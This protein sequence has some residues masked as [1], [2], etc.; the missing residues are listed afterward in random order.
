MAGGSGALASQYVEFTSKGL[1]TVQ[2]AMDVIKHGL[3]GVTGSTASVNSELAA[4]DKAA[5][6][7][8]QVKTLGTLGAYLDAAKGKIAG[9]ASGLAS[10]AG[11]G[12]AGAGAAVGQ[13]NQQLAATPVA[14]G[15]AVAGFQM[16][17]NSARSWVSAGLAG[18]GHGNLMQAQFQ[19]L[20]Q[21]IA[22]VFV[23]TINMVTHAVTDLAAW[24][25]RLTGDQQGVIRRF[26]EA[27]A[28]MVVVHLALTKV[29]GMVISFVGTMIAGM[30]AA[31]GSILTTLVP[32]FLTLVSEVVA[33]SV[34]MASAI[35]FASAGIST[36]LGVVGAV[37]SA[38]LSLGIAGTTVGVGLAVG[39]QSGRSALGELLA[40]LRPVA[41]AFR[42]VFQGLSAA[43]GPVLEQLGGR[44]GAVMQRV[45]AALTGL[46]ERAGPAIASVGVILSSIGDAVGGLMESVAGAVEGLGGPMLSVFGAVAGVVAT[47]VEWGVRVVSWIVDAGSAV[48]RWLASWVTIE[49]V[50]NVVKGVLATL[51]AI[52]LPIAVNIGLIFAAVVVALSPLIAIVVAIGA[53]FAG[54]AYVIG[55]VVT[56]LRPAWEAVYAIGVGVWEVVKAVGGALFDA[57]GSLFGGLGTIGETFDG[58][59]VTLREIAQFIAVG[60]VSAANSLVQ[61]LATVARGLATLAAG[62]DAVLGTNLASRLNALADRLAAIRISVGGPAAAPGVANREGAARTDVQQAGGNFEAAESLFKRINETAGRTQAEQAQRDRDEERNR[63]LRE[64]RD[65]QNAPPPREP[66]APVPSA[67]G[68]AAPAAPV[69]YQARRSGLVAGFRAATGL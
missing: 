48:A 7:D 64:I 43:I 39:T 60:M 27:G 52:L 45:A 12:I 31:A 4:V 9:I 57:I 10:M 59:M 50:I 37:A 62:M 35:G 40:A 8:R 29:T 58:W 41:D 66:V 25:R 36:I 69:N 16:L 68:P 38:L 65:R 56:A 24:F 13:L 5:A 20:S 42:T 23:P 28:A 63:L 3:A 44:V 17:T 67:A 61:V 32:A 15:A 14:I 6:W 21:Q 18:T 33:G 19:Q 22:G 51:A 11:S 47:L 2:A 53:A 30:V 46:F 49:G 26:V 1:E 55:R 54:V 34:T